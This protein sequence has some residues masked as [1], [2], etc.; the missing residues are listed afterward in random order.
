MNRAIEK[1]INHLV[2]KPGTLFLID[3]IGAMLTTLLLF[4]VL[5]NF[6]GYF[7]MPKTALTYLS[8]IAACFCV[9]SAICFL[10]L[11]ENWMPFIKIISVANLLYCLL[12]AGLLIN[13]YKQL[14]GL[15]LTY[16]WVEIIIICGLVFIERSVAN[17]IEKQN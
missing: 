6:N 3:S 9:Y 5:R 17:K 12:T 13:Y 15:G 2:R 14:T 4:F 16:F 10:F 7:G 11:K 8:A 1:M